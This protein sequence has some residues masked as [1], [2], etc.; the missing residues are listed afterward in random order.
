[1]IMMSG[2]VLSVRLWNWGSLFISDWQLTCMI[3]RGRGPVVGLGLDLDGEEECV[4]RG[5]FCGSKESIVA[6]LRRLESHRELYLLGVSIPWRSNSRV[7]K[8]GLSHCRQVQE[9]LVLSR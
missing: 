5:G 2:L 1:M 6:L 8:F 7:L 9:T 4:G 3:R